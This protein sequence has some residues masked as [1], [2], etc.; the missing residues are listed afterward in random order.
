VVLD[1]AENQEE[2]NSLTLMKKYKNARAEEKHGLTQYGSDKD[3]LISKQHMYLCLRHSLLIMT[4]HG[5]KIIN[6]R[7]LIIS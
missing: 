3:E 7:K 6:H 2:T 1:F 4:R 5:V